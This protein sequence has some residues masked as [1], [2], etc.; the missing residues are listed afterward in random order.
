MDP[1]SFGQDGVG[2]SKAA[3]NTSYKNHTE[4]EEEGFVSFSARK[5]SSILL[6]TTEE[7]NSQ[8]GLAGG[9][10]SE[11]GVSDLPIQKG[12]AV[13]AARA[14]EAKRKKLQSE[15]EVLDVH[16]KVLPFF[17]SELF[18]PSQ[19]DWRQ[20]LAVLETKEEEKKAD[21][22]RSSAI[23]RRKRSV[24]GTP[25]LGTTNE[26]EI[27]DETGRKS[28]EKMDFAKPGLPA[29]AGKTAPGIN[30]NA[31]EVLLQRLEGGGSRDGIDEDDEDDD[32]HEFSFVRKLSSMVLGTSQL[33]G[34]NGAAAGES[35]FVN[36]TNVSYTYYRPLPNSYQLQL[37]A[38]EAA[39]KR[40]A[41]LQ[42]RWW[43]RWLDCRQS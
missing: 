40:R 34:M 15:I 17:C 7:L 28:P 30:Y 11:N 10:E 13:E 18:F 23:S 5:L 16:S 25:A 36:G 21:R 4:P 41:K 2:S 8:D 6:Q 38:L 31:A 19:Q 27:I 20:K 26:E 33:N 9:S 32:D 42:V 43:W 37:K 12:S 35:A 29:Q 24:M 1:G 3:L 14:R 39:A 22:R